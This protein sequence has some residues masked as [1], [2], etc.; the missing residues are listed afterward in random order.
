M[1]HSALN[2]GKS[3]PVNLVKLH[4]L[5][6]AKKICSNPTCPTPPEVLLKQNL[7]KVKNLNL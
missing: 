5:K 6:I 2:M 3:L 1:F 7:I 4:T